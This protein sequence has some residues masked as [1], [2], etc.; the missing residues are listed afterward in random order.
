MAVTFEIV[1]RALR[2]TTT[3]D[4]EYR[5]GL[6]TLAAGFAASAADP[7][8]AGRHLLFDIRASTEDRDP[9]E[10]R[11]IATVI[12]A[13][14]ATLSGRCVVIAADPLHFGL[15]R[16]FGVFIE[17]LG[18]DVAVFHTTD[19]ADRWLAASASAG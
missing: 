14:R 3:G 19:D 15:A 16:M 6:D 18:F 5:S 10:L 4:V 13:N 1:G 8:P 11:Q 7:A 17:G 12:S 9:D 2:F